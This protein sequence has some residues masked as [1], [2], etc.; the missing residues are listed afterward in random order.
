MVA[1]PVRQRH[2]NAL[3]GADLR[4]RLGRKGRAQGIGSRRGR[5]ERL[6]GSIC[7]VGVTNVTIRDGLPHFVPFSADRCLKPGS[8][9]ATTVGAGLRPVPTYAAGAVSPDGRVLRRL[10]KSRQHGPQ[11]RRGR[12]AGGGR[13]GSV[14]PR[15]GQA[16]HWPCR[17]AP[18]Q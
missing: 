8:A 1:R 7:L 6:R 12:S 15:S 16:A 9:E 18:T 10:A 3:V 2:V 11:G 17:W 13:Q 14:L 4:R 5:A